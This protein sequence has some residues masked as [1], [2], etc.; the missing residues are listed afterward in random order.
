MT[1]AKGTVRGDIKSKRD[2]YTH[3]NDI[4]AVC[5][6]YSI[7]NPEKES[8]ITT[9]IDVMHWQVSTAVSL[10]EW[11]VGQDVNALRCAGCTL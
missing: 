2:N 6:T 10:R 9:A 7:T 11:G 5:P 4:T 8:H 3:G 1:K